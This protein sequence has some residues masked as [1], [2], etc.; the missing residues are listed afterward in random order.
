MNW[1][2]TEI[3]MILFCKQVEGTLTLHV[4]V[5]REE[6]TKRTDSLQRLLLQKHVQVRF[7]NPT[8]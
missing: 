1:N 4:Q 8:F 7:I 6:E 2:V 3:K 5:E